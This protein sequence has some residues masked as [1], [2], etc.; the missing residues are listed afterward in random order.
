MILIAILILGVAPWW[1]SSSCTQAH[2]PGR[3]FMFDVYSLKNIW[4]L[5]LR[6]CISQIC[7]EDAR[8]ISPFHPHVVWSSN[9]IIGH[10]RLITLL[11]SKNAVVKWKKKM[12]ASGESCYKRELSFQYPQF[13]VPKQLVISLATVSPEPNWHWTPGWVFERTHAQPFPRKCFAGKFPTLG[14]QRYPTYQRNNIENGSSWLSPQPPRWCPGII[15]N[16][17]TWP[18]PKVGWI[19][20]KTII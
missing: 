19:G 14:L 1:S 3:T 16:Y 10:E 6:M 9:A 8:K 15:I 18:S 5:S 12:L 2:T 11:V 17:P 13:F 20:E 4:L 7:L